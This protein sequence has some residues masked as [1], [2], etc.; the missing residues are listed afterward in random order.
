[1]SIIPKIT[2]KSLKQNKTRTLV[3]I[4]GIILSA[5]MIC[6]V[7]T[8]AE[9][10]RC[11]MIDS[12][13]KANGNYFAKAINVSSE[14]IEE[15]KKDSRL[16]Q[17]SD[18]CE[19][20]HAEFKPES[21]KPYYR[22]CG[23]NQSF[24]ENMPCYLKEGRYPQNSNEIIISD[25]IVSLSPSEIRIG[26]TLSLDIGD[27][28]I[29]GN[30]IE[31]NERFLENE[32]LSL[33]S[34]K[35]YTIVGVFYNNYGLDLDNN[36]EDGY[37]NC[38]SFP[39][40]TVADE[41]CKN[42]NI[43]FK[44][45]KPKD[46]FSF[47]KDH[48]LDAKYEHMLLAFYGVSKYDNVQSYFYG[49]IVFIIAIIVFGSVALIYNAFSIS[50]S[51]RT[52]Q[53]GL[54]SSVGATKKQ[55]RYSVM[56]EA[57]FVSIIGIP[58]GILCGIGGIGITIAIIQSQI[59][60]LLTLSGFPL[61]VSWISVISAGAIA[62]ITVLISALI[63]ARRA[64]K[65]TA[66]EAIRQT[67]DIKTNN[68]PIKVS[69][70]TKKLFGFEGT[71]AAKYFKRNRKKYRTTVI[72]LAMSV[73]LFISA[74][75]FTNYFIKDVVATQEGV[76]YDIEVCQYGY[77]KNDDIDFIAIFNQTKNAEGVTESE[78]C[79]KTNISVFLDETERENSYKTAF[80]E[81]YPNDRIGSMEYINILFID[82]ESFANLVYKNNLNKEK[83]FNAEE[84][85]GI[86][87]N[88]ETI[89][90][91]KEH[92]FY[93][94]KLVNENVNKLSAFTVIQRE[95][96]Y[97]YAKEEADG[98]FTVVYGSSEEGTFLENAD[99]DTN[100]VKCTLNIGSYIYE[101]TLSIGNDDCP[102]MIYPISAMTH[103][104]G[105]DFIKQKSIDEIILYRSDD[106]DK[107]TKLIM[108]IIEKKGYSH[109][110]LYVT[111][112]AAMEREN[113]NFILI[114]NIFAYGFIIL[115]SLIAAANVFNTISTNI[116]LRRREFAMLKTV[117]MTSKGFNKM[118]NLECIMYGTRA[119]IFGLPVSFA[120]TYWIYKISNNSVMF[121][122]YIPWDA[123]IIA[124]LSV[125]IVVFVTMMYSMSKIKKENTI[126]ALKNENL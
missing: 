120:M 81:T 38:P 55:I 56:F 86:F 32:S 78:Y 39:V 97:G 62:L 84:P 64:T 61:R 123:V 67:K 105:E 28:T 100:T 34:H 103:V 43:L 117:G 74:S 93:T 101:K 75:A 126:D 40:F 50:V 52:Q 94:T 46:I 2:I 106:S 92:K 23:V 124:T 51:E 121:D 14:Q 95:G 48:K 114:V 104:L 68:K 108:D 37:Y 12:F 49:V 65:C 113:R 4:I 17:V 31:S 41:S 58:I 72:S 99:F 70:L 119:L 47:V 27:R 82:D 3:T 1:M 77:E 90:N 36:L 76:P 107:T 19:I 16:E 60:R 122:F 22:I 24:F 87:Y 66:I 6:A 73:V 20:G 112:Y 21:E 45:Y 44:T 42:F 110:Y 29:A 59:T 89:Y 96:C 71:L 125:F 35:D 33:R 13:I 26:D 85:L 88:K 9:T 109:G 102:T 80:K 30:P 111:D 57:F 116:N 83:F 98:S 7:T 79:K 25:E 91:D 15:L 53:F 54:L 69:K 63:P 115:I 18:I 10:L 5:A 118:M 8:F 11:S